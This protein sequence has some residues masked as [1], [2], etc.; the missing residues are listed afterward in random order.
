M[1]GGVSLAVW[2]GGVAREMNLLQQ[3]S[4][5]RQLANVPVRAQEPGSGR[6][7]AGADA[8]HG[9]DGWSGAGGTP[10]W[11]ARCRDLYL[12]LLRLLNVTVT[13]DVLSGTSGGAINAALLGLSSAAGVDLGALRAFWLATGSL[14]RLLR[15]AREKNPPSLLQGDKVLFTQL[16][17]GIRDLYGS[18]TSEYRFPPDD[19]GIDAPGTSVFITTT[20]MSG[21]TS[22]F[23]DDFGTLVPDVDYHGL[24]TFDEQALGAGGAPALTE[25]AL[26]VRCSASFPG[27]FE[28]SFVPIGSQ[29][30]AGAGVP[31]RPDMAAFANMTRSQWV[32]DGGLLANRPLMPLLAK[33][34]AQ[35]ATGQV[36][37]VLAFVVPDG[38]GNIRTTPQAVAG[39]EGEHPPTLASAL[40]A[41]LNAQESQSIASDLQAARAHNERIDA[42]H[43]LRRSLADLGSRLCSEDQQPAESPPSDGL[44]NARLLH[45][46]QRQQGAGLAQ[47]LLSEVMSQLT[48]MPIPDAWAGQL[49]PGQQAETR[50]ATTM[51]YVLGRG[52]QGSQPAGLSATS[53]AATAA[54]AGQSPAGE[55][56]AA[57]AAWI[58]ATDPYGRAAL[59]GL[60]VFIAARTITIQLIR[61][62]YQRATDSI[63]RSKLAGHRKA[64]E[65]AVTALPPGWTDEGG[66]VAA[67]LERVTS[68]IQAGHSRD[69]AAVAAELADRKRRALLIGDD[70]TA[71]LTGAWERLATAVQ[72]L[73]ADLEP[74][75]T[76]DG[77]ASRAEAAES[78]GVYLRYFGHTPDAP[79]V[80][81]RLLKLLLAERAL[82]PGESEPD[83][84][85]ELVQFSANTRTLLAPAHGSVPAPQRL[86]SVTK[87]RGV[88]LHRFAAFYKS[89]WRAWDWMWGRLDGSGWLVH[90]L[91]DPRR[92]LAVVEDDPYAFPEGQRAASFA[93][94]LRAA[95]GLRAGLP[96]DCLEEDLAFLDDHT[97]DVPVSLP[98]SALFVAQAWQSLVTANELPAIARQILADKGYLPSPVSPRESRRSAFPA[99]A[100]QQRPQDVWVT[101]V[102]NL[103]DRA[104]APEDFARQLPS[105]PVR[106]ET[107]AGE[108]RTE[109]FARLATKAAA[110]ATAA[111]GGKSA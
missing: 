38:G 94:A 72:L 70:N 34:F 24:F 11:D 91:L 36:R 64:I 32:A 103:R 8:R 69:L 48:T 74:L 50:M 19:S 39:D 99:N 42:R 45:K 93:S 105:C 101:V 22:R 54:S 59:F 87:L 46:F 108:L 27:A 12:R 55:K 66:E 49:E 57:W 60:P 7:E 109:A 9:V 1:S 71:A 79:H 81:D 97:A 67:Y 65:D 95:T 75:T 84:P 16:N 73:L 18:G 15:N 25:L 90:I 78:I 56:A 3:A 28:P 21:E 89:S 80:A 2:M 20:M 53:G 23:T 30:A 100:G 77:R 26:A 111:Q 47:P 98:N 85:V 52:W 33:V 14:D 68:D 86:D 40:A 110:V 102:N 29:V 31:A 17:N 13:M 35:P 43:G 76:P 10:T 88:E 58:A 62:G 61:L 4:N 96:G 5:L 82:L 37:R 41:D 63:Q 51:A 104:A 6:T 44:V 83:Q 92:I 106:Q 107:L